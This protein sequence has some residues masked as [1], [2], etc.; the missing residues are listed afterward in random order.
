MYILLYTPSFRRDVWKPPSFFAPEAGSQWSST[1]TRCNALAGAR[2]WFG[3]SER[4][5]SLGGFS[6]YFFPFLRNEIFPRTPESSKSQ[7]S[8]GEDVSLKYDPV[9]SDLDGFILTATTIA[10]SRCPSNYNTQY[11]KLKIKIFDRILNGCFMVCCFYSAKSESI[12]DLLARDTCFVFRFQTLVWQSNCSFSQSTSK[13]Y[14]PKT[15]NRLN[16]FVILR[17]WCAAFDFC[18]KFATLHKSPQGH[19]FS[20]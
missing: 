7:G 16:S 15:L 1:R 3:R 20:L 12:Y 10:T 17:A 4:S 13:I 2:G 9:V 14:L 8:Q 19:R 11:F 18:D 6:M 5:R